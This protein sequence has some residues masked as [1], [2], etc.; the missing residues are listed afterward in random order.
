MN[1]QISPLVVGAVG[2]LYGH[3]DL[4]NKGEQEA[5][6]IFIEDMKAKYPQLSRAELAQAF[7][8]ASNMA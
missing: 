2:W 3:R 6:A 4:L 5:K 7:E 1:L 8:T